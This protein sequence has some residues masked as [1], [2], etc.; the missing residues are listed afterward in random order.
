MGT[1]T[2]NEGQRYRCS[3]EIWELAEFERLRQ[4]QLAEYKNLIFPLYMKVVDSHVGQFCGDLSKAMAQAALMLPLKSTFVGNALTGAKVGGQ[5]KGQDVYSYGHEAAIVV[6]R[7]SR[8]PL[9][10]LDPIARGW[11]GQVNCE[12]GAYYR[13]IPRPWSEA[14]SAH[15]GGFKGVSRWYEPLK[16]HSV[17]AVGTLF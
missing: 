17:G 6:D 12:N 16:Q 9:V 15:Y 14:K 10:V 7:A 3:V 13:W 5:I 1:T 4:G 8:K 2:D 11:G